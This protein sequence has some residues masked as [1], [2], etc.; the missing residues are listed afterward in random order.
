MEVGIILISIYIGY[1]IFDYY[2]ERKTAKQIRKY[3]EAH[4][5]KEDNIE[6]KKQEYQKPGLTEKQIRYRQ[7]L[8]SEHWQQIRKV[9]LERADHKCQVCGH[10]DKKLNVHHNTY[11]NKG[12]EDLTDLCVLCD[13]C[14]KAFHKKRN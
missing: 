14:H 13:D 7:Y 1:F 11:E 3:D 5:N 6:L 12:H 4:N 9:A 8:K 10:R 2:K